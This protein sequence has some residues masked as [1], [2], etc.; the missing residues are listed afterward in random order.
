MIA[1]YEVLE[2][3]GRGGMGVVYK[4]KDVRLDRTVALKMLP[5][6]VTGD[7]EAKA[8]FLHEG[9]AASALD[10]SSICTIFDVGESE[11]GRL[12]MAMGLV[13]GPSLADLIAER[14]LE[15][16][17]ALEIAIDVGEGL[18]HS[19]EAG[20]IHRDIK[21]SNVMLTNS[22]QVKVLDFGLARLAGATMLTAS[23]TTL[24]TAAYMSP[25]QAGGQ[26]ADAREPTSG[27]SASSS[28]R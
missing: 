18:Q 25:E 3:L 7:E 17:R 16:D 23:G 26:R 24:G 12:F 21:P 6:H 10:H 4:A 22:G 15:L 5:H 2:E 27:L 8:R 20:V 1:H 9:R 28:T 13:D 19:H 11:D 14:P